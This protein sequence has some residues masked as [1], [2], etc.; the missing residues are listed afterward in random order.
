MIHKSKP[1]KKIL[2]FKNRVK[3]TKAAPY[4]KITPEIKAELE[5]LSQKLPKY[6]QFSIGK[7]GK[8]V[9]VY[10]Y[11]TMKGSEILLKMEDPEYK[12]EKEDS[13]GEKIL[14]N[15]NYSFFIGYKMVIHL[16]FLIS[17]YML[18]GDDGVLN[19]CTQVKEDYKQWLTIEQQLKDSHKPQNND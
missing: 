10:L 5:A 4:N 11:Y 16:K 18:N 15:K 13:K 3:I 19:Y 14:P 7:E 6:P 8:K 12:G 17:H 9:P 1:K 2:K